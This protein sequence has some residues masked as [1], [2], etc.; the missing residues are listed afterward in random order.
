MSKR[1]AIFYT[2]SLLA[3]AF[4]GLLAGGIIEA[5][6]GVGGVRGW[7]WLGRPTCH[8]T[9]LTIRLFVLEGLGTVVFAVSS[10]FIL[11]GTWIRETRKGD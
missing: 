10:Y 1:I 9:L 2:A 3:G 4:G 8:L 5:M 6:E 7:R 11:P